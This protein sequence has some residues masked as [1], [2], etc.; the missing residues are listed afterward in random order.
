MSAPSVPLEVSYQPG[1]WIEE[2]KAIYIGE[3]EDIV[4]ADI[5]VPQADTAPLGVISRWYDACIELKPDTFDNCVKQ[6]AALNANGRKGI[7]FDPTCYEEKLFESLRSGEAVNKYC[8][9]PLAVIDAILK[10]RRKGH[11]KTLTEKNDPARVIVDCGG[12]GYDRWQWSCSMGRY[13]SDYIRIV[14]FT[15]GYHGWDFRTANLLSV[16]ACFCE[17]V[18][19]KEKSKKER[20][21]W[22]AAEAVEIKSA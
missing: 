11:Y 21:A 18:H 2:K 20:V 22:A 13:G 8:I 17:M 19:G 4:R 9:A 16:R 15:D 14:D 3:F 12:T 10:L 5:P 1:E 7:A 6:V